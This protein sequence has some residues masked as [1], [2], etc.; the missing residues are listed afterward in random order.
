[1]TTTTDPANLSGAE[2][3]AMLAADVRAEAIAALT[4]EQVADLLADAA[5]WTR[6]DGSVVPEPERRHLRL[7]D[8]PEEPTP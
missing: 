4:D 1:M 6:P 5:W 2:L 7:V 3:F 8:P